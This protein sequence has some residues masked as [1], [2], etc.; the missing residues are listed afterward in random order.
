MGLAV[1]DPMA[2]LDDG[3]ADGLGEVT[4]PRARRHSHI[5][6]RFSGPSSSTMPGTPSSANA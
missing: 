5:L 4:L 3:D 1:E 2:L 6:R